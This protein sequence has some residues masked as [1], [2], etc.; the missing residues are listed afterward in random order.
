MENGGPSAILGPLERLGQGRTGNSRA[1]AARAH[2]TQGH[3]ESQI[4]E[5]LEQELSEEEEASQ[6]SIDIRI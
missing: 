5:E 6:K 2:R 1:R 3:G 4:P